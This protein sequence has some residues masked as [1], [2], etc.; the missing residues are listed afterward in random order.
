MGDAEELPSESTAGNNL[1]KF[2][3]YYHLFLFEM[4]LIQFTAL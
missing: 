2:G 4:I 1:G 3:G